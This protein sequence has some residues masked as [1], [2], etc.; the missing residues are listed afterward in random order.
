MKTTR[1]TWSLGLPCR[2]LIGGSLPAEACRVA[3]VEE[4][5]NSN[6]SNGGDDGDS[7]GRCRML[8][9]EKEEGL[10]DANDGAF[11]LEKCLSLF[12]IFWGD[13]GDATNEASNQQAINQVSYFER[14]KL[15]ALC[16]NFFLIALQLQI[17][18][19]STCF[20]FFKSKILIPTLKRNLGESF[21]DDLKI[22]MNS[23][24]PF[25]SDLCAFSWRASVDFLSFCCFCW[26]KWLSTWR[27]GLSPTRK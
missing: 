5:S 13:E 18:S 8:S 6:C 4:F 10:V 2:R 11:W 24:R 15:F 26:W 7:A 21:P 25:S 17:N 27:L 19:R 1:L 20:K 9:E 12:R 3:T 23:R 14:I 22:G 16:A